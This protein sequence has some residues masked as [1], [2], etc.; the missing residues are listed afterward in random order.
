MLWVGRVGLAR[1]SLL[2]VERRAY[3]TDRSGFCRIYTM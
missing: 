1:E 2:Q 3:L